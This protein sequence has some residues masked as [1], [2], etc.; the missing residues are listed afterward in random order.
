[1]HWGRITRPNHPGGV[2]VRRIR[3]LL[4]SSVVLVA[5]SSCSTASRFSI[6][7]PASPNRIAGAGTTRHPEFSPA[8]STG[9]AGWLLITGDSLQIL[10]GVSATSPRARLAAPATYRLDHVSRRL[11]ITGYTTADGRWHEW[12]GSV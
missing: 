12:Y 3:E 7:G 9:A 5:L 8:E 1:M 4:A 11:S 2:A 10:K 6:G